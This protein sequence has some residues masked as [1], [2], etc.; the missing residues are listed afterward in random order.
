MQLLQNYFIFYSSQTLLWAGRS[1]FLWKRN[2]WPI[3]CVCSNDE[4]LIALLWPVT[5]WKLELGLNWV[6]CTAKYIWL[7]SLCL[8]WEV[9][10]HLYITVSKLTFLLYSSPFKSWISP[11][12]CTAWLKARDVICSS[13]A[14]RRN[15][16]LHPEKGHSNTCSEHWPMCRVT[17]FL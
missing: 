9:R 14:L 2:Y 16:C 12:V 15:V 13:Q 3:K 17:W 4:Q 1:R 5:G 7:L 10:L 6:R 11:S 8:E